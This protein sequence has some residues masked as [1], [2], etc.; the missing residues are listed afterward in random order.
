MGSVAG[1]LAV[2]AAQALPI[3][4]EWFVP[5]PEAQI[6]LDYLV[7]ASNT[8]TTTESVIAITVPVPGTRIVVDHWEDGY[9]VDLGNPVQAASQIWGD[10]N[11]AN[12]KPPG[13]AND[14]SSFTAGSVIIM[15]NQVPL[16]RNASTI[17]HDGRD[18]FGST[19]GIV[20]TRAAWFTTP[21]PL[22]ANSVE[23][24]AVPDWGNSFILPVGEDII[25]PAP[26]GSSMFE[27]CSAYIM[28]AQNGTQVQIDLDG[29]GSVDST[30]TLNQGESHLVNAGI[31]KGAAITSSKPVQ[32]MQFY[33]DIGAN[34]EARGANVPPVTRWSDDYYAPVGT[35]SDGDE[36]YVFL[37]N[38][39]ASAIT[40]NYATKLG[41]GS[42]SVPGKGTYQY[43]MPQDS[44]A[45]F[46]SAGEK[47]FWGIGTV[48]ARPTA[49]NVHDWGYALVP[50]DFLSTEVVV[51]WGAGSE[52]GSQNG[53]PVWV[54][55]AGAT[56]IYVDYNGDRNG[57]NT[58]PNGAKY[59]VFLDVQPLTISRVFEP[60]KDQSAMRLYTLNG[61]LI[62]AAWGQDPASA[63]AARPYLDLGN[64]T[65]NFPVPVMSKVSS[66][67]VDNAPAG[68]SVG[69]VLEYTVTLDNRSLFSL[70]SV[71]VM[72]ALPGGV[73]YIGGTT[74]RDGSAVADSGAT[75]FPLDE[76]G[77]IVPILP[78]RLSTV[79]QFR[80]TITAS[81]TLTNTARL[82]GYTGVEASDTIVVPA[83]SGS[84][85]CTLRLT[86]GSGSEVD[87]Q[88]GDGIHVTV[89][90]PDSNTSGATAQSIIALVENSATG[91]VEA[92]T[93]TETGVNTGVFRNTAA[94]PSST[95]AGLGQNDGTLNVQPGNTI[96]ATHVDP[97]F[98]DTCP[99]T[100]VIT[101]PSLIKQ[102][103]LDTGGGDA[104]TTGDLD[105][106]DPVATA[107]GTTSESALLAAPSS[108]A[109]TA[110]T[111]SPYNG[112]GTSHSFT[113]SA[114]TGSDRLLVVAAGVGSTG[115][116]G[117]AGTIS[118]ATFGGTPMV[119]V[120]TAFS[121]DGSRVY[122]FALK[123]NP[124]TSYVMPTTGSVAITSSSGS[125]VE[126][127]A[128]T[129]TGVDQTTPYGLFASN[130]N[131]GSSAVS[132]TVASAVGQLV[133]AI[134]AAD[135]GGTN[136]SITTGT[137]GGQVQLWSY[138]GSDYLSSAASTKPGTAGDVTSSFT[139]NTT[140]DWA[141]GAISLRPASNPGGSAIFT[142]TPAFAEG[143]SM[144][145]G[146]ILE[147]T[148]YVEVPV[149]S[150]PANPSITATL[151]RDGTTID[152]LANPT[153]TLLSG[154]AQAIT[155]DGAASTGSA[156]EADGS[157]AAL[158]GVNVNHT[159]GTGT[160][161]LML[162][163]LNFE[164]DNTEA[165]T[166]SSVRWI[167]GASTQDLTL[168][169]SASAAV[170]ARSQIWSLTAPVSGAGQLQVVINSGTADGDAIVAGVM[171]FSGVDQSTPLGTA[172]NAI[173][174]NTSA[175]VNVA[176]SAGQLVFG[177]VSADDSRALTLG[178]GQTSGWNLSAGGS[179]DGV[180]GAASTEAGA[181]TVT[182]SWTLGTSD[183]WAICGVPIRSAVS[184]SIYQID[185]SAA[186]AGT[187]DL[188]DG[189]V[190]SLAIENAGA[191][192]FSLLYD[193]GS[194]PSKIDLPTN[195][196][197]HNDSV[198]VYDAPYPGGSLITTP[199]TGQTLYVRV[200]AGDPFGAYDITS[201][202]LVLDGPGATG[203]V[204]VTLD[205]SDMVAGTSATKTYEYVWATGST[206]GNFTITATAKEGYENTIVSAKSTTVNIS[207][208]DLGTPSTTEFTTGNNGPHTLQY[209]PDETIYVRVVDLDE[210]S[211]PLVAETITVTIIGSGGDV[212]TVTLTETG[213][214]TGIFTGG[215]PASSTIPGTSG[216]GTLHALQGS[217]P[218]V[219]YIDNDD[220]TDTGNDTAIIPAASPGVSVTKTLLSPADGQILVNETARYRLRVTNTGNSTLNTV[221][222]VDTFASTELSYVSASPAPDTV[223]SGSLTWSN[224]GPLASGQSVDVIVDFTGLAAA[225]P[226]V[227]TVNVTTGPG[228]PVDSDTEPVIVT[229]PE[230]TVIKSL[231]SPNP[232]PANKGDEVVFEISVQNTGTTALASV[233]LEDT[234]S[235]AFFDFVSASVAPDGSGAGGLL[236][237]DITGAGNLAVNDTFTVTVTLR[238]KGAADSAINHAAVDYAVDVYGDPVPPS[239]SSVGVE[240]LAASISGYVYE[241]HGASGFGGDTALPAVIVKLYSDPNGDGDPSD[242]DVVAI[243]TTDATGYYEF[244][245]LGMDDYVVAEEDLL[246]YISVAD[247]AGANDNR[248]PVQVIVLTSYPDNNFL[249]G[250]VDPADYGAVSGQV[251][252][253]TDADSNLGD[254]D[255]GLAGAL[256]TLFTDPN[257]DGD[258]SDGFP[259]GASVTTTSTGT[260]SFANLPPGYYVVAETDPSGFASTADVSNPNDNQIPVTVVASVTST[261]N[262]FLDTGNTAALASIGNRIW[263]D[264]DNDGTL[265][266]G[267]TGIDGVA[268]ELY[269]SSQ[270]PGVDSPYRTQSTSGGGFYQ[271]DGVP[272]GVYVVY[273]PASNFG[274][275][276]A[277]ESSPLSSTITSTTDD[278]ID[279]DDNGIQTTGG[280]AVISPVI[281]L[282]GGETDHGKD[283]GFVPGASFGSISGTVLA[284]IE[285]D[286][287]G[288]SPLEDVTLRLLNSLGNPVLDEFGAPVTT[289]TL[290][291]GTYCFANLPPGN[292]CVSQ[293]QP[294]NYNSVS[295]TDG[296]NDNVIGNV[297]PI[298]VTPGDNVGGNDFIEIELGAISGHVL[299]DTD[300]NGTGD[301]SLSG[302]VLNLLDGSGD[303]VLDG[304]G[305]PIQV[306]SGAGGYYIFTLVPAGSYQVSQNQPAG[307]GSVS[308]VDGANNNAI[309]DETPIVITP[310]LVVTGRDFVEIELGSISGRVFKD[311]NDDGF[312]DTLF[313]GVSVALLDGSGSP[314]LDG[315]G[316]PVTTVTDID[317]SYF[318]DDLF[319]GDYQVAETQPSGYG[320]VS[321]VDG[322]NPDLIGNV[323]AIAVAPGQNVTGRD[324][325]EIE[326]GT[327]SGYVRVGSNPLAG[328]TVTL[329]DEFGDPVDGDPNTPEIEPITDVTSSLGYYSFSGVVP[330]TYQVGET[331]PYGYNSFGDNDG[332]DPDIIGDRAPVTISPGQHS[333]NNNFVETLD[334]CPDDWAEWKFQ[335]PGEQADGNPDADAYDNLAEFAFAMPAGNGNGSTWLGN[336]AWIIQP[337]TLAPGTIEGVFV[338]PKGAPLN[339]TYTLQYAAVAGNPTVWQSIA[340]TPLMITTA[341]NGDCTETVTIHDLETVTGLTGG[342]GVV[343]I[344]ADL[345]EVPLTGT[346]HVS[347]SETEGWK[348]TGLELCCR[349]YNNPF[350]RETAF[351]G[352][353][354]GVSGQNLAFAVSGGVADLSTLL[355]PGASYYLEVTSG[356][357]EG[358]RFDIVSASGN[359]VTL[360]ADA[361][362]HAATPPFNT[363]AGAPP[364]SLTN[365]KAVIRRHWTIN[366]IFPVS[367]FGA[368]GSQSTADQIQVFSGGAWT[369]YW[370]Y[371]ENDGNPA[372]ARWVDA[373]DAG[374]AD[375]GATV[376][377]PG[378]GLF[379]NNR[380]SVTSILAYGEIR[381]NAFVRPLAVGSNLVG[382]GYPANQSANGSLGRAMNLGTGFF[383]SRDFK[384]ADSVFVWKADTIIDSPGYHTYY[385]FDGAPVQ[386]SLVRWVRM[387]DP[388][389]LARDSEILL[390]GNRS[391][392]V[393]A[394]NELPAYTI[395]TPW[396]P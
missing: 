155:A 68:L 343:R 311:G 225:N 77:L 326:L 268:V 107:D 115:I 380:S 314:V 297:V 127:G 352:T 205:D 90:D 46:T 98:G 71:P 175:T 296:P 73:S 163:G 260:Y 48:G 139:L 153:A 319:P 299:L 84:N 371:D 129:F 201:L 242:G 65:P 105:R 137:S 349:T 331:Q 273:L 276:R 76:T 9:E 357:N 152:T 282:S 350:L 381:P 108:A 303:P 293:D 241:D 301:S 278:G 39:D 356:D 80:V 376:I 140:T 195:T 341:D 170:E 275:G 102:L 116:A 23:V 143:F 78:A 365:D 332:G 106:V 328:I 323:A 214:D 96:S 373:A 28:A 36:T 248:I 145:A 11:D 141:A 131:S 180:T 49:N 19:Y 126:A 13:Y 247:T 196:V 253:D 25:F 52:D 243:T 306:A 233:P 12:G 150:L 298:T 383:G 8:N 62:T 213:S 291:N 135:E 149:G 165:F 117:A 363:L 385:L 70:A 10:G 198:E 337:S 172:V 110:G 346:D 6:R 176:S 257:G 318:F 37:Y 251:R 89:T 128:T 238:A 364:V 22:L 185:W 27:H 220:P 228:G 308:D 133:V 360:A 207:S 187:V 244:L 216:N 235:D 269:F 17:L 92:V 99:D 30:L 377:P 210:N 259:F 130:V 18:R 231:V 190:L 122:L 1:W 254:A 208:L 339:V 157:G 2:G 29:N 283:F 31:K 154:G 82:L 334:T 265:D 224:V 351:T 255:S 181:A 239:G 325:V 54:T 47:P 111:T 162:A 42:F 144:P 182:M 194:Y 316:D 112:T 348:E 355:G 75:P 192:E 44:A 173:G 200:T 142:Q 124:G 333:Q 41:T 386:P 113:H 338:R 79:I 321:D 219:D 279:H 40:V 64:T 342:T 61:T 67:A 97:A 226:S 300:D 35:A 374:M 209:A 396:T 362:L 294:A 138:G 202:P 329:L 74:T 20:M 38:P 330:G 312:G 230:V 118:A 151:R 277:L 26:L 189:Q 179:G 340:I 366:E 252:D 69:D 215:V 250:I 324:F 221:Q 262:D 168:V 395:P 114:N 389:L 136:L 390:L 372:T 72:D 158:T 237:N 245:N 320:S 223:A 261:G 227:N 66:L 379:F 317:G 164:D 315:S 146:G 246:G 313:P 284:D 263:A 123:D 305:A 292:Y 193:S 148:S 121:G 57:P 14:P 249:D 270:T 81:G 217:V 86:N 161:R 91:D 184:S 160:N 302:V 204:S 56:R 335:H 280:A 104:D 271:F 236:W 382:G 103:Y 232:G 295:D 199:T 32:V 60:D 354:S 392:F 218:V 5:Q 359:T 310:G 274:T 178:A 183:D 186:L 304:F 119:Q 336:T 16:P 368:T 229:R 171:T 212:E 281:T 88:P 3:A 191:A 287:D 266:G 177:S 370:L 234:F 203:D 100:A 367:G 53:N 93:L 33:G 43:L 51:G 388:S 222:V 258:P 288:D 290:A 211:N 256:I 384:T 7:L 169:T 347:F 309:G 378:Q 327:I 197:I 15:R 85:A 166:I 394:K 375:Q 50:K 358:Q 272:A 344:K 94:L 134:A 167:V 322:G 24:R 83:A 45:R 125:R 264:T 240:T 369:I 95:S 120:G 109:I 361:S 391:V 188:T 4:Q 63:G 206:E 147:V 21:G 387:G 55:S 267:E 285:G 156:T 87:Y 101:A 286:G 345:D 34:Y 58:D 393:R 289:T 132:V 159:T 174:A 353:V 59:D 307:Y